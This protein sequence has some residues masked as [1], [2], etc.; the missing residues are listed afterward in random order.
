MYYLRLGHHS[1]DTY[2]S[3]A[4]SEPHM[5]YIWLQSWARLIRQ[6]AFH[7][8]GLVAW[9]HARLIQHVFGTIVAWW[10]ADGDDEALW[11]VRLPNAWD[12]GAQP[13]TVVSADQ[14]R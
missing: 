11:K 9:L 12:V 4:A 10:P 13:R 5:R 3:A 8:H 6:I 2:G 7:S 1:T 14:T